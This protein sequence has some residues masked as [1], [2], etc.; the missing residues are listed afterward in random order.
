M[1]YHVFID[2]DKNKLIIHDDI[3]KCFDENKVY[4]C[5]MGAKNEEDLIKQLKRYINTNYCNHYSKIKNILDNNYPEY[6]L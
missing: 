2:L 4:F 6:D 1:N 5:R 3:V